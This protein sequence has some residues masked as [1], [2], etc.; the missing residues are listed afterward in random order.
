MTELARE[1]SGCKVW[2]ADLRLL[3]LARESYDGIWAHRSLI[4]LTSDECRRALAA[5]FAA[6]GP[7]GILFVSME[8]GEG[9]AEDRTDDPS[10]PS[11]TI[12][13]Y[14]ADDFASLIRQHGFT[15]IGSGRDSTRPERMA[16][17]GQRIG[18]A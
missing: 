5:F 3:N 16:F 17:I 12:Y 14:R 1:Q 7:Q 13:R 9:F 15:L 8:E 6:L 2:Q 18:S 10:G 4:H 11:R